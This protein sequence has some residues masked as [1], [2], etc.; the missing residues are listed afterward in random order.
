[1]RN[2]LFAAVAAFA[3]VACSSSNNIVMVPNT[4]DYSASAVSL[5]YDGGTVEVEE[6]KVELLEKYLRNHLFDDGSAFAE[7]MNGLTIKYGFIGYEEGSQA[8]RYLAGPIAGGAKMVIVA[9]F[10]DAEG[11]SLAKIQSEGSVS[12][13]FFGGDSDSA[14]NGAAKQ[15]AS[16]AKDNFAGG[17]GE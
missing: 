14:I 4:S 5:E 7:G 13:G 11:N 10:F 9:E 3:L 1:M 15:I 17:S 6:G 16:Y 2:H 8:A 12:G